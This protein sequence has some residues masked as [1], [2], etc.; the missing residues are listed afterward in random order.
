MDIKNFVKCLLFKNGIATGRKQTGYP[1]HLSEEGCPEEMMYKYRTLCEGKINLYQ[2]N[3]HDISTWL[4][5]AFVLCFQGCLYC[6]ES[7]EMEIVYSPWIEGRSF[8][9][10]SIVNIVSASVGKMSLGGWA[11]LKDRSFL[12]LGVHVL[13]QEPIACTESTCVPLG[14]V[15]QEN[16]CEP[17]AHDA[18]YPVYLPQP[19][20]IWFV[21]LLFICVY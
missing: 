16:P 18:C 10:T 9:L 1:N 20:Y 17:E 8:L 21:S 12:K 5:T 19:S 15:E 11:S 3:F 7:W 2:K 13:W 14:L 6:K 4:V